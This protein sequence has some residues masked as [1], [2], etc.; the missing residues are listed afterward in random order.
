MGAQDA[1]VLN[2]RSTPKTTLI[3]AFPELHLL[4]MAPHF[5]QKIRCPRR[6]SSRA[7]QQTADPPANLWLYLLT[8]KIAPS[9]FGPT[10][11]DLY[12]CRPPEEETESTE[13]GLAR[14]PYIMMRGKLH[15]LERTSTAS[16]AHR[17]CNLAMK[18]RPCCTPLRIGTPRPQVQPFS[19]P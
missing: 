15:N 18:K 16:A 6:A 13:T 2:S 9:S 3:G 10:R 17:G 11:P 14:I 7:R 8:P 19:L 1:V 12:A 5:L 4:E